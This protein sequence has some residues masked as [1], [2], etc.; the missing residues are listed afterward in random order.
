ME[1][2]WKKRARENQRKSMKILE[3]KSIKETK[4]NKIEKKRIRDTWENMGKTKKKQETTRDCDGE[5]IESKYCMVLA[6]EEQK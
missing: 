3:K 5:L 6:V 1:N 4:G 2:R